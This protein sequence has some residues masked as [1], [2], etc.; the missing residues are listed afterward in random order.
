MSTYIG[1]DTQP[2][3]LD[4]HFRFWHLVGVANDWW[5]GFSRFAKRYRGAAKRGANAPPN[6]CEVIC[7]SGLKVLDY[8]RRTL[9]LLWGESRDGIAI[10]ASSL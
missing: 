9:D 3:G 8:G 2:K 1:E 5:N 4:L 10:M 7:H 6:G